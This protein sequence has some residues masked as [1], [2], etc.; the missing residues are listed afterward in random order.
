[1]RCVNCR[2][3][4]NGQGYFFSY[5]NSDK[6]SVALD[7]KEEA[8]RA[9]LV[10]LLRE[11]D[12]LIQNLK[13][14]AFARMGFPH[15]NL[16]EI[17]PRLV[18]CDISGFGQDSIYDG[19]PAVDSIVQ[20]MS[21]IMTANQVG[22]IPMKTGISFVDLQ[23][24]ILACGAT[25]AALEQRDQSGKGTN[26]DLAMHDIASWSTQTTWNGAPLPPPSLILACSDGKAIALC[27]RDELTG[28]ISDLSPNDSSDAHFD[29]AGKCADA[30]RLL[31]SAGYP[32]AQLNTVADALKHPQTVARKL[33]FELSD[34]VGGTWPA[35]RVPIH[36]SETQPVMRS[37]IGPIDH[38]AQSIFE[39]RNRTEEVLAQ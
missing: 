31:E 11:A 4:K 28:A 24:A 35:V 10:E 34:P 16:A 1:M 17:N 26:V 33:H 25:L 37:V 9:K 23:V 29:F 30:V 21:G 13:E 3:F 8:D 14:G 20:A 7:L 12:V 6:R 32:A 39:S 19:R 36:L 38:D 22:G 27:S 18:R 15:E 5:Y 2:P